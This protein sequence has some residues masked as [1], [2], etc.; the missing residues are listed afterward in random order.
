LL[1]CLLDLRRDPL[2]FLR[3]LGEQYGDVVRV[4]LGLQDIYLLR[5]PD[6]VVEVLE[7]GHADFPREAFPL[8]AMTRVL[9]Q[10]LLTSEG[11][12]WRQQRR[13]VQPMFG[14]ETLLEATPLITEIVETMLDGWSAQIQANAPFDLA[15]QMR[16]FAFLVVGQVFFSEDLTGDMEEFAESV[17]I[18]HQQLDR[19]IHEPS[20]I[21]LWA[22]T[23]ENRAYH[24]HLGVLNRVI[25]RL[26]TAR[27]QDP[28]DDLLGRLV[29]AQNPKTGE[30]L[31][32]QQVRDQALNLLVAGHETT[33]NALA[34]TCALLA[35]HSQ[36]AQ[37]LREETRAVYG[38]GAPTP[39]KIRQMAYTRAVFLE[40]LRLFPTAWLLFRKARSDSLFEG[41]RVPAGSLV[42][43]SPYLT[44]R[45]PD[46]WDRPEFF[47]PDRH[48]PASQPS[49][50]A[51]PRPRGA[52]FP[53]G[54]G[55]HHCIGANLAMIE[56]RILFPLLVRRFHLRLAKGRQP[57]PA[58]RVSLGPKDGVWV[59]LREVQV[60]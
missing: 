37:N 8:E 28:R 51:K 30:G 36:V 52:F 46:F 22:P 38:L 56:A 27:R 42:A 13:T 1:G 21:P 4:P 54:L 49:P 19:R 33:S 24:H 44:H 47:D 45:H 25:Q 39:E 26:I 60:V 3:D 17:E 31:D 16:H 40:T 2:A 10:G 9:G 11:K 23:R 41:Y 43:I 53:F 58:P 29:A 6:H 55:P 57:T 34:W 35:E 7:R 14:P 32:D 15:A 48:L 12:L 5:H 20:L 50:T 18:L 59:Q